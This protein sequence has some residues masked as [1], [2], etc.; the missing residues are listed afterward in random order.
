MVMQSRSTF[1][2]RL[3]LCHQRTRALTPH[4]DRVERTLQILALAMAPDRA[5]ADILLICPWIRDV[6]GLRAAFSAVGLA[7]NLVRVDFEAALRVALAHY[8]FEI[9]I[10]ATTPGLCHELAWTI[11]QGHNPR[12]V[13]IEQDDLAIAG[14]DAA[15]ALRG[16]RS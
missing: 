9:A 13:V 4:H 14:R 12:L 16:R 2:K 10:Y 7:P 6:S 3:S 11:V 15:A 5:K 1:Q 8:R